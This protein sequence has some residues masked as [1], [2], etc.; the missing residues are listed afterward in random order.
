[1]E[2]HPDL[3][4]AQSSATPNKLG[5]YSIVDY[6]MSVS[7]HFWN[8]VNWLI[9]TIKPNTLNDHDWAG[10]LTNS[11][12]FKQDT[13]IAGHV[14]MMWRNVMPEIVSGTSHGLLMR[15]GDCPSC[16]GWRIVS[17]TNAL[18]QHNSFGVGTKF[19][20]EL[21]NHIVAKV[22]LWTWQI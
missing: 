5:S 10:N 17:P 4:W 9:P 8:L 6:S 21:H 3:G 16:L 13:S 14:T 15:M 19:V 1:M 11:S 12:P 22:E 7:E 18:C 20:T 2:L